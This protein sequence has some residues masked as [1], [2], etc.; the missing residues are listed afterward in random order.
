MIKKIVLSIVILLTLLTPATAKNRYIV[1][2]NIEQFNYTLNPFTHLRNSMN[3][4]EL[5]IPVDKEYFESLQVGQKIKDEFRYGS[6]LFKGSFG[7][8]EISVKKKE[9]VEC[10]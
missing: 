8:W 10:E 9:I 4:I 2:F 6:L 7:D 1:T 3:A 5:P